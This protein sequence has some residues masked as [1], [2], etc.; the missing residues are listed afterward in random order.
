[1]HHNAS[2]RLPTGIQRGRGMAKKQRGR[3]GFRSVMLQAYVR[4]TLRER[5][6]R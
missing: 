1:M 2:R 3:Q 6:V 4:P 5:G